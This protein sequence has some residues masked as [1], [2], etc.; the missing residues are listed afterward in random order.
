MPIRNIIIGQRVA[1]AK[2]STA[3]DLRRRMTPEE[4]LLWRELR[5]NKLDGLHFRRQQVIQGYIADFYCHAAG[6]VIEIDGPV[7][8]AQQ[9]WDMDREQALSD[10]GLHIIRFTNREVTNDLPHVLQRILTEARTRIAPR[11]FQ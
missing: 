8:D 10:I 4:A 1:S 2:V 11:Q 6:L 5:T 7:H 3:K 9:E